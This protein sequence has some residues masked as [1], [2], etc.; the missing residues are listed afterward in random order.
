MNNIPVVILAGGYGTRMSA[1]PERIPKPLVEIGG[2]PI[3]WHIMKH[4]SYYKFNFFTILSGYKQHLIKQYFMDY[5]LNNR[6]ITVDIDTGGFCYENQIE[7]KWRVSVLDT[8]LNVTTG[9]RILEIKDKEIFKDN[10]FFCMTYGDAVSNVDLDKLLE[11]HKSHGKIATLTTVRPPEKYG[12]LNIK[13]DKVTAYAEK[14]NDRDRWVNGGFF[15]LGK[16][17]FDYIKEE[18]MFEQE[19]LRRLVEDEQLMAYHHEGFWHSMDTTKEC[20][21]LN[22]MW[23]DGKA[24]WK[25]W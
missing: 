14:P 7:E 5:H 2:K 19:P 4:Y 25:V 10:D 12:I 3:L 8:G 6:D 23:S 21:D 24:E 22:K 16:E 9:G 18:E 11:F 1:N 17:V 15:I 20:N 13:D